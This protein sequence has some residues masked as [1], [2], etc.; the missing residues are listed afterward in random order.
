MNYFNNVKFNLLILSKMETFKCK[1][2]LSTDVDYKNF[3]KSIDFKFNHKFNIIVGLMYTTTANLINGLDKYNDFYGT[4]NVLIHIGPTIYI[5]CILY[6]PT[7]LT[8]YLN[9]DH[10]IVLNDGHD[11]HEYDENFITILGIY[12]YYTY[13]D[14]CECSTNNYLLDKQSVKKTCLN[15]N[16]K[17]NHILKYIETNDL[18]KDK[19]VFNKYKKYHMTI[20]LE[21]DQLLTENN[22]LKTILT[23]KLYK[24]NNLGALNAS[25]SYKES[26]NQKMNLFNK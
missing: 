6:G 2:Q 4:M 7:Y 10:K 11:K 21:H 3:P 19:D 8:D 23:H 16:Y 26:L 24:S 9:I 13:D 5:A 18:S 14:D 12:D 22:D 25:S 17:L 1:F 20:L 15:H